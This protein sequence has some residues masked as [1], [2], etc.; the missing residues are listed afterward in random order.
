MWDNGRIQDNAGSFGLWTKQAAEATGAYF[1]DLNK[2]T[3]SKLQSLG[4]DKGL[5][6]VDVYFS[7]D[8]THTSKDGAKLNAQSIVDGLNEVSCNLRDYL[9]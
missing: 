1:I 9:K 7:G 3:G 4:Y 6:F 2:I 8:H 5:R